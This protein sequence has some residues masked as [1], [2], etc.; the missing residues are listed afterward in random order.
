MSVKKGLVPYGLVSPGFEAV[1]TGERSLGF[2][3]RT[4]GPSRLV[5]D[6][7]GNVMRT[8]SVWTWPGQEKD[9]DEE[10][11]HINE[12]QRRLGPL[13]DETRKIRAHIGS[14]VPCDNGLPVTVDE[15]LGA[16]SKGR[17]GDRSFH[18]GCWMGSMWWDTKSTQPFESETMGTI[19]EVLMAC[20]EGKPEESSLE[21]FP[22][23]K[24]FIDRTYEWLGPVEGLTKLQKLMIERML[25]PLDFFTWKNR[26][27]AQVNRDCFEDGGR[28]FELD[29]EISELAGLPKIY[30]IHLRE[31]KES[32]ESISDPGKGELYTVCCHIASGVHGLSDCHHNMLRYFER[33]IYGIG[34]GRWGIPARKAGTERDRLEQLL[35][36]YTLGLDK[37]LLGIPMHFLFLDLGYVDLGFDPKNEILRVYANLGQER[38]P[39]KI[40]LTACLWYNLC[41]NMHGGL[42]PF[43]GPWRSK[44][45]DMV[46]RASKQRISIR[47][48]MDSAL[49]RREEGAYSSSK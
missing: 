25:L 26:D 37:W 39:V 29:D 48:W 2:V 34:T 7:S 9:W 47:E 45:K 22:F 31:Y 19:Y 40:W 30:P 4:D 43:K 11:E 36:G 21:K 18:N 27:Y 46:E 15:L 13:D 44:H 35:F 5:A 3:E 16:I 49:Q 17:L 38:T 41:H 28:G 32:L 8:W 12:M 1:Y 24:G 42:L 20:L 10:I 23:A 33:W 6:D 14:L